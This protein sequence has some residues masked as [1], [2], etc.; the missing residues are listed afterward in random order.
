L[1]YDGHSLLRLPP[2]QE[3][4]SATCLHLNNPKLQQRQQLPKNNKTEQSAR[5]DE[6]AYI[7]NISYRQF[8]DLSPATAIAAATTTAATVAA[9]TTTTTTTNAHAM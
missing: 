9:A 1:K 8:Y 2:L 6:A 7:I 3:S 5:T 4:T